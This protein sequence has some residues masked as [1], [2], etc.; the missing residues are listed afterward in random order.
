MNG[1]KSDQL[2][3]RRDRPELFEA[4]VRFEHAALRP[5]YLLNGGAAVA[6]IAFVG[7]TPAFAAG[8]AGPM[9]L[10]IVGLMFATGATIAGYFSQ[11]LFFKRGGRLDEGR[12]AEAQDLGKKGVWIRR[13]AYVFGL[14]SLPC[15]GIGA[16]IAIDALAGSA[17][18]SLYR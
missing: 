18:T 16:W 3:E 13:L 9:K 1:D 12:T 17:G 11:L 7:K 8:V 15:F 10:W 5:L 6:A 14:G 2:S 4:T